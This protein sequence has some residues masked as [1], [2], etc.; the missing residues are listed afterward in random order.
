MGKGGSAAKPRAASHSTTAGPRGEKTQRKRSYVPARHTLPRTYLNQRAVTLQH[1]V[2]GTATRAALLEA[3]GALPLTSRGRADRCHRAGRAAGKEPRA[4]LTP[5]GNAA[6]GSQEGAAPGGPAAPGFGP[7]RAA[8]PEPHRPARRQRGPPSPQPSGDHTEGDP[9]PSAPGREAGPPL[10]DPRAGPPQ[11]L[12]PLRAPLPSPHLSLSA[13]SRGGP[14]AGPGRGSSP[15][16][17][18]RAA[19]AL[20]QLCAAA[21][22]REGGQSGGHT[23]AGCTPTHGPPPCGAEVSLAPSSGREGIGD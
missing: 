10:R 5:P 13:P 2:N 9:R 19:A 22:H 12:T 17:A 18:L 14:R 7:P 16:T 8:E 4:A 3:L 21:D 11:P 15:S 23:A 20:W 1:R 6:N